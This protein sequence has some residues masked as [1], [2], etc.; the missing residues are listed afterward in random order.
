MGD[1][2]MRIHL[3]RLPQQRDRLIGV[4]CVGANRERANVQLRRAI[5]V[6]EC[7]D[8]A[9]D[10]DGRSSDGESYAA[11]RIRSSGTR[12]QRRA[13]RDRERED[14][15]IELIIRQREHSVAD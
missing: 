9:E 7:G 5:A 11:A 4:V 1:L 14:W 2:L 6:S 13:G 8:Q 12:D 10:H 15:H 3:Q